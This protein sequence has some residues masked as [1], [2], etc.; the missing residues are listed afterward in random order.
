MLLGEPDQIYEQTANVPLTT[1]SITSRSRVQYWEY[2][3]Y[4][5]RF[6]FYDES[7]TGRWRLTPASES[8]FQSVNARVLVH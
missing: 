2:G 8:D 5:I 4:R 6:I 7:G 3:Q 1:S